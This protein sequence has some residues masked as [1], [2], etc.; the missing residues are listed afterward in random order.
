MSGKRKFKIMDHEL[1]PKHEVVKPE[2]AIE[3]LKELGVRPENLPWIRA[4]DPVAKEIGAKPGDIVRIERKSPTTGKI[5]V[6][7]FVV[8]G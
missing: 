6:Y 4:S 2:E 1:V 7:R 5:I 8:A 3:I